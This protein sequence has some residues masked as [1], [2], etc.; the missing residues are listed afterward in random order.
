MTLMTTGASIGAFN[1][2]AMLCRYPDVVTH[3][4]GMSGTYDIG[5]FVG[6]DG[7]GD[8]LYFSTPNYFLGGLEGPQLE[9]L[10]TRQVIL[11]CGQG[12]WENIGES[13]RLAHILGSKGVPNR[14]DPWGP[15]YDHDWPTW[16]RMLPVYL[17]ELL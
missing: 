17:K 2:V 15:E 4:V 5:R 9:L 7:A 10:R 11:A 12:R 13:W 1:A 14:V 8:N 3:A 6:A 16:R